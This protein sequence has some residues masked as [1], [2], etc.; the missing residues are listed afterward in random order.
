MQKNLN[1]MTS[2]QTLNSMTP[3]DKFYIFI[4][5]DGSCIQECVNLKV[6]I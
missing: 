4:V 1:K 3:K 5:E 2:V 6:N